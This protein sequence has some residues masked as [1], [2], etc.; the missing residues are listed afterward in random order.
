MRLQKYTKQFEYDDRGF[1][2]NQLSG[3]IYEIPYGAYFL[4]KKQDFEKLNEEYAEVYQ[5]L[6]NENVIVPD[7]F[8]EKDFIN[9]KIKERNH[10]FDDYKDITVV[11]A[12]SLDCNFDC[13]YCFENDGKTKKPVLMSKETASNVIKYI[14]NNIPRDS[15]LR[16]SWYGGEPLLAVDTIYYISQEL[17]KFYPDFLP[18]R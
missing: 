13:I 16:I 17:K 7:N 8:N 12:P 1:V 3:L 2:F 9:Q 18:P 5:F 4:L 11:I 15:K 6:V 14:E 10:V